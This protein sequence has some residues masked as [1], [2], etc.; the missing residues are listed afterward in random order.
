MALGVKLS[1][2]QTNVPVGAWARGLVSFLKRRGTMGNHL[3]PL[4]HVPSPCLCVNNRSTG[5][6]LRDGGKWN[7]S[8]RRGC[9]TKRDEQK[10]SSVSVIM[11][12][13]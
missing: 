5:P 12:Q 10:E 13:L 6:E 1:C 8:K 7:P 9:C 11:V 4:L 3:S 2:C